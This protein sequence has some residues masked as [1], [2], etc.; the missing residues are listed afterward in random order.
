MASIARKV[1]RTLKSNK[2]CQPFEIEVQLAKGP[3]VCVPREIKDA[4]RSTYLR[5]IRYKEIAP[6]ENPL[7]L[8]AM[9]GDANAVQLFLEAMQNEKNTDA[10]CS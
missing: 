3:I 6:D 8:A 9:V 4:S 10:S 1:Y 7:L 2:V 5:F